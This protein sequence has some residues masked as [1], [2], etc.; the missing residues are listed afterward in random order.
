MINKVQRR[1]RTQRGSIGRVETETRDETRRSCVIATFCFQ[2]ISLSYY[3]I[4][5]PR[6][7]STLS[8]GTRGCHTFSVP[9]SE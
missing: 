1:A 2:Q 6:A 3:A 5:D 7:I 4:T 9:G 8:F